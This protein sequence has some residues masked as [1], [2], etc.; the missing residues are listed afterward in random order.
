MPPIVLLKLY[1][2]HDILIMNLI[3]FYLISNVDII[4]YK[5]LKHILLV[6][7]FKILI[8]HGPCLQMIIDLYAN[9]DFL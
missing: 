3:N 9:H 4:R 2:K 7:L 8:V 1:T 5:Q 6:L